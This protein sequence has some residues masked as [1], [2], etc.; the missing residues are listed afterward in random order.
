ME[1]VKFGL[2]VQGT[3]LLALQEA[4][5]ELLVAMFEASQTIAINAKVPYTFFDKQMPSTYTLA[6]FLAC[7]NQEG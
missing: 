4:S 6:T 2:R 3:A 7:Y 1:S 5:E